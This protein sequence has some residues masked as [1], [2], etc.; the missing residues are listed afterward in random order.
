[1][2]KSAGL[3]KVARIAV[4]NAILKDRAIL[5]FV[6]L[7]AVGVAGCTSGDTVREKTEDDGG[8][9][10]DSSETVS[11]DGVVGVVAAVGQR[12]GVDVTIENVDVSPPLRSLAAQGF[13]V[14]EYEFGPSGHVFAEAVTVRFTLNISDLEIDG[15]GLPLVAIG[16]S[17]DGIDFESLS[18]I[19]VDMGG[20][21][22]V[23]YGETSQLGR[24]AVV[25]GGTEPG[26]TNSQ[27]IQAFVG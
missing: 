14:L 10:S 9:L 12:L 15:S 26:A 5:W 18:G 3:R 24:V 4:V 27:V 13:E 8:G 17:S 25:I 7:L 2:S 19:S 23:I 21:V 11:T 22:I 20:G 1:L 16:R 6:I